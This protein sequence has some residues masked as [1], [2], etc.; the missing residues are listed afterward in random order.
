MLWSWGLCWERKHFMFS[1]DSSSLLNIIHNTYN[2]NL[3]LFLYICTLINFKYI[4]IHYFEFTVDIIYEFS[5]IWGITCHNTTFCFRLLAAPCDRETR[6]VPW[7]WE[8]Q[9]H[10]LIAAFHYSCVNC[11]F[12]FCFPKSMLLRY[13]YFWM[14]RLYIFIYSNILGATYIWNIWTATLLYDHH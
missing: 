5:F 11:I 4:I 1:P 8:V 12:K 9:G 6:M 13:F 3:H 10:H 2:H 7:G 14:L